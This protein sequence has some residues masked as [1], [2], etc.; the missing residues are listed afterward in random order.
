MPK[1]EPENIAI[2]L[3]HTKE[4]RS[5]N[6]MEYEF[7]VLQWWHQAE[8]VWQEEEVCSGLAYS[9]QHM[10]CEDRYISLKEEV[11]ALKDVGFQLQ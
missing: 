1:S 5:T 10:T 7:W 9:T 2:Y 6:N 11:L 3:Q 4:F 8:Y